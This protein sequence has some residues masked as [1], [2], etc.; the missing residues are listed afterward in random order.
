MDIHLILGSCKGAAQ[1][2]EKAAAGESPATAL[3]NVVP[4][5]Y[6]EYF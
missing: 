3:H 4:V 6:V 2:L 5:L 1:K